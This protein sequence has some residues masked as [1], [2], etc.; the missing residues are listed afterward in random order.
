MRGA[1][2]PTPRERWAAAEKT[3]TDGCPPPV[4]GPAPDGLPELN[5][6]ETYLRTSNTLA[7]ATTD[8]QG[9]LIAD[10]TGAGPNPCL[11]SI[12]SQLASVAH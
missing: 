8:C 1:A 7:P 11:T 2:F 6:K 3:K 12:C 5:V 4:V 10:Q 9:K